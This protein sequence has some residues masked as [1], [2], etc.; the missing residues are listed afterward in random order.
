M[1]FANYICKTFTSHEPLICKGITSQ[2][3]DQFLY[4]LEKL[5]FSP[6]QLCGTII[7]D[8]G[9]PH[10]PFQSNWTIPLPPKFTWIDNSYFDSKY[11]IKE[12]TSKGQKTFRVL[13]LSDLHFDLNYK[14]GAEAKCRDPVCCQADSLRNPRRRIKKPAGYWGTIAACDIPYWTIEN[15]LKHISQTEILDY[16]ILSG[17]YM[18]H[19]DWSYSKKDHLKIISNLTNLINKYFPGTPV[20]WGIGNHEGVPVNTFAPHFVPPQFRPQWLYGAIYRSG[21]KWLAPANKEEM[22]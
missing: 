17:D 4:V 1:E 3:K 10:N 18:S 16:I 12:E 11:A 19:K 5:L 13:Q 20:F 22:R 2:F 14:P 7:S 6:A 8:C 9:S 21:K 15:M